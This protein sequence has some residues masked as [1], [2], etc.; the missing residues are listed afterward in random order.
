MLK[1]CRKT[2][3]QL[4][5][6]WYR[7]TIIVHPI[8]LHRCKRRKKLIES[9][10]ILGPKEA[11]RKEPV[12]QEGSVIDVGEIITWHTIVSTKTQFVITVEELDIQRECV[13][14]KHLVGQATSKPED[15]ADLEEDVIFNLSSK[16]TPPYQV[17]VEINGKPIT[18]EIDT[19]AVVSV[20]SQDSWEAR[21]AE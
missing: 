6:Q 7:P 16:S 3:R 11:G 21:F 12:E 13:E 4:V 15:V 14:A 1:C 2:A 10:D 18:V 8:Q 19:G 20:M 17:V 5:K 9:V